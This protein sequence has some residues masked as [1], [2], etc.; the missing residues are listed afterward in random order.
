MP[1]VLKKITRYVPKVYTDD[2]PMIYSSKP[3]TKILLK[4]I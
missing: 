1:K 3:K 4:D 2:T